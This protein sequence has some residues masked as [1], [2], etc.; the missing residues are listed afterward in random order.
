VKV[1][2]RRGRLRL[3][4]EPDEAQLLTNLF[5]QLEAVDDENFDPDDEVRQRLYPSAYPDDAEA[6]VEYRSLTEASLRTERRE[7]IAACRADLSRADD[8]DL[9]DRDAGRRWIQVLNDLRLSL[10]TRLGV[11]EDDDTQIDPTAPDAQPRLVYYWLTAVQDSVVQ[12][13]MR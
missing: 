8:V 4:L 2:G 10:G 5:D 12:G 11:T 1:T 6:D 13:L 9:A 3:R 7:R